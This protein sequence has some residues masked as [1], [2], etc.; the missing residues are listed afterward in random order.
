MWTSASSSD[1]MLTLAPCKM[2]TCAELNLIFETCVELRLP[3][4]KYLKRL[5]SPDVESDNI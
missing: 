2:I 5:W 1:E 3:S 4:R